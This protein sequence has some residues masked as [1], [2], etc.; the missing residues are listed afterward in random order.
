MARA[1][2]RN[3]GPYKGERSMRFGIRSRLNR[4][5]HGFQTETRP[6]AENDNPLAATG[7]SPP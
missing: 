1:S 3:S 7:P 5:K 6:A 2:V 4:L